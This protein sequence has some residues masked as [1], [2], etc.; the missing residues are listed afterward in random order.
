MRM[1]FAEKPPT[2]AEFVDRGIE[3]FEVTGHIDA[4]DPKTVHIDMVWKVSSGADPELHPD[5][6]AF[7][8]LRKCPLCWRG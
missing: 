1:V 2:P 8:P 4:N 3:R 6:R 7:S 5:G